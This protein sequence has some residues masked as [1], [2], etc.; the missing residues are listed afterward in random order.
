M[1]IVDNVMYSSTYYAF[2]KLYIRKIYRKKSVSPRKEKVGEKCKKLL[3][4]ESFVV[5]M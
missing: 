3:L 4:R 5:R 2:K 1:Y